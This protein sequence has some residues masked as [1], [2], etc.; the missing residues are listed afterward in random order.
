MI[1]R[2]TVMCE[3]KPPQ[4]PLRKTTQL[5][6]RHL[7]EEEEEEEEGFFKIQHYD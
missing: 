1:H 6:V 7:H 4:L 2:L 5:K 3:K